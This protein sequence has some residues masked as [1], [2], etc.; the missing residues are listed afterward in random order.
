MASRQVIVTTVFGPQ[1]ETIAKTFASFTKVANAELHVFVYNPALPQNRHPQLQYHLVEHDKAFESIRR[2]ALFRRW[3]WPDQLDA[4]FALVVDGTDAICVRPLPEFRDL[5]R[6]AS[7]AAAPE[8]GRPVRILGQGYTSAYL[9]AGVTFWNLPRS[10]EMREEIAARGRSH[11]R[12][13]FD[14]QTALN[15]VAHTRYFDELT[16]LPSQFNWRAF[17]KKSYRSWHQGFRK[18]PRVDSLDGVQIYHNHHCID[19]VAAALTAGE[20]ALRAALPELAPDTHPLSPATL[21]W[22]R[23]IHRWYFS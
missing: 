23:L 17:Y 9:N 2:D 21:F 13:P 1:A 14:D 7:V 6:G 19:E 22:R 11:Y 18:W 12:G 4:E 15:E 20:P 10:K 8:W 5:L 3:I 16:V